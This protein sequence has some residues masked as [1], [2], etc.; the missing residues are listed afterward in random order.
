MYKRQALEFAAERSGARVV[1]ADVSWPLKRAEQVVQA[2]LG[3]VTART[4]LVLIS[5][6]TSPTGVV[7]PV[8]EIV[9]EL[10]VR[11]IDALVDG[12]HAPGMVPLDLDGLDAAYY[13]GNCHKWMCAPKGTAFVWIRKDRRDRVRPLT[14]SHGA[15]STR[16]D[17]SRLRLEFD[18]TGTADV[19][20]FVVLPQSI[21]FMESMVSGGW[22]EIMR[23]NRE[24]ALRGREVLCR[25]LGATMP[26]PE[27]MIAS[28][29][30]VA[31][32]DRTAAEAAMPTKYHD[33][34]QDRLIER[35]GIQAPIV[36][37]PRGSNRRMVRIAM[38]VYN[39]VEQVEYL[40]RALREELGRE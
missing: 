6:V 21:R 5:H 15:N 14:I 33:A 1:S 8:A 27:S 9:R 26:A 20:G 28:L 29:A 32:A 3:A 11:G 35:W 37:H 13:A 24:L 2:V 39:T 25:E 36:V 10:N 38:Q 22:A 40:A 34:L 19:S 31:I 30:S 4:R 12:A 23:R 17:R 7:F 18:Y 16:T